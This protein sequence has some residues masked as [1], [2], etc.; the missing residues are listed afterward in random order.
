MYTGENISKG[1]FT[2]VQ[3][4]LEKAT[5]DGESQEGGAANSWNPLSPC[6]QEEKGQG[7]LP[8]TGTPRAEAV[9]SLSEWKAG[10]E[11]KCQGGVYSN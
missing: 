8:V 9:A 1:V 6:P 7:D 4:G 11:S 10:R 2:K 3:A 5:G